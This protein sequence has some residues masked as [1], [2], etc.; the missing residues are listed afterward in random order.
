V[1]PMLAAKSRRDELQLNRR[2]T[3]QLK[4]DGVRANVWMNLADD[5]NSFEFSQD[6]VTVTISNREG[7]IINRRYPEVVADLLAYYE[8]LW[9]DS[10]DGV[11]EVMFDG[12]IVCGMGKKSD[13]HDIQIRDK[14]S[15]FEFVIERKIESGELPRAYFVPF[16]CLVFNGVNLIVDTLESRLRHAVGLYAR[17]TSLEFGL[18][19]DDPKDRDLF[20]LRLETAEKDGYEGIIVKDLKS[21]YRPGKRSSDWKK[22]KFVDSCSALVVGIEPSQ[23]SRPFGALRVAVLEADGQIV[24]VGTVGSGFS[25]K[26]FVEIKEY[27]LTSLKPLIIEVEY[28]DFPD[29]RLRQPVYKGIR[30]DLMLSD[31]SMSQLREEVAA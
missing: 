4:F 23:G 16:D 29:K 20:N 25:D 27:I 1:E 2:F 18:N 19:L 6:D 11:G 5:A 9:S 30:R 12:E 22:I 15:G 26:D 17:E 24:E 13:F 21:P 7:V 10:T 28:L 31:C 3:Y 14:Q 8:R